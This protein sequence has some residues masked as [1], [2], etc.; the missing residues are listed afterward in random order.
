MKNI[1]LFVSSNLL[2]YSIR[3]ALYYHFF[4]FSHHCTPVNHHI[5]EVSTQTL[6]HSSFFHRVGG[7]VHRSHLPN[8]LKW[9]SLSWRGRKKSDCSFLSHL[10]LI[11]GSSK[12]IYIYNQNRFILSLAQIY[13]LWWYMHICS[14]KHI[15]TP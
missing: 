5:P 1:L 15:H 2:L 9:P 14:H 11:S 13:K 12:I 8:S 7:D 4:P 6:T 3:C 10:F